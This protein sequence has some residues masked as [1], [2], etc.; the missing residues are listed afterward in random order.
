MKRIKIQTLN[1]REISVLLPK[2]RS[3]TPGTYRPAEDIELV[4][5]TCLNNETKKK[6]ENLVAEKKIIEEDKAMWGCEGWKPQSWSLEE[7]VSCDS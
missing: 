2:S 7:V 6:E 1:W 5:E 3:V 4:A